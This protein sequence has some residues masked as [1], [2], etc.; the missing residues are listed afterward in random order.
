MTLGC[1]SECGQGGCGWASTP[2][3]TLLVPE[4][5]FFLILII[6]A[7][8]PF[9]KWCGGLAGHTDPPASPNRAK[10]TAFA[11]FDSLGRLRCGLE[12]FSGLGGLGLLQEPMPPNFILLLTPPTSLAAPKTWQ[13]ALRDGGLRGD[14]Q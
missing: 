8:E 10:N 7:P 12:R 9:L 11:V 5:V 6:G 14:R 4:N 2:S 3:N 1:Q 13:Q